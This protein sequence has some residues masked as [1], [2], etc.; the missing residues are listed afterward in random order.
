[1]NN[2]R[3]QLVAAFCFQGALCELIR[4][5]KNAT[6]SRLAVSQGER[7]FWASDHSANP[8][9]AFLCPPGG[10]G[11][12]LSPP[13][14]PCISHHRAAAVERRFM[15]RLLIGFARLLATASSRRI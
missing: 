13:H 9:L 4:A 10:D 12:N 14:F 7:K 2:R 11:P 6:R 5:R 8:Q 1:M 15:L 3:H